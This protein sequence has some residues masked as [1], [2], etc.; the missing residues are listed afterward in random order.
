MDK[1]K[2]PQTTI[3]LTFMTHIISAMGV[4][5]ILHCKIFVERAI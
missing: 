4:V 3:A 2:N 1:S 5:Y